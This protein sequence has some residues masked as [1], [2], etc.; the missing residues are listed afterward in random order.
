VSAAA[1]DLGLKLDPGL[2][3]ARGL[4]RRFGG[5]DA[6][7]LHVPE[8]VI[9]H[10]LDARGTLDGL[11]VPGERDE[12]APEAVVCEELRR[13]GAVAFG[14]RVCETRQPLVDLGG[15]GLDGGVGHG[16]L[17]PVTGHRHCRRDRTARPSH[18]TFRR[19]APFSSTKSTL[20]LSGS[21]TIGSRLMPRTYTWTRA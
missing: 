19:P 21:V 10:V 4:G 8:R 11:D 13:G 17:L 1:A 7:K 9:E 20:Y 6:A 5:A 3:H 18:A 14:Q 12:V 15:D 16:L 2:G